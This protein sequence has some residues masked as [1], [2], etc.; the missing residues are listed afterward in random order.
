MAFEEG[1]SVRLLVRIT[2][3]WEGDKEMGAVNCTR[4]RMG[5]NSLWND[6]I[7]GWGEG[8]VTMPGWASCSGSHTID[9]L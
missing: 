5:G 9:V 8:G 3:G 7:G 4:I 2:G 1:R 6:K